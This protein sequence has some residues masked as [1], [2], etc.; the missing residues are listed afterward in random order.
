MLRLGDGLAVERLLDGDVGHGSRVRRAVRVRGVGRAP[1]DGAGANLH[2]LLANGLGPAGARGDDQGLAK[3]VGVPGGSGARLKGDA[4]DADARGFGR[5]AQGFDGDLAGEPFGRALLRGP[6]SGAFQ[7]HYGFSSHG[8]ASATHIG[9]AGG[10]LTFMGSDVRFRYFAIRR[11]P[12][13]G[14]LT[15]SRGCEGVS[16]SFWRSARMATRRY[17]VWPTCAGPQAVRSSASWVRTRPGCFASS[18]S[19]VHSLGFRWTSSP[20]RR[21]LR[22]RRSIVIGPTSTIWRSASDASRCRSDARTR[23]SSSSVSNG[24]VT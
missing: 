6:R 17:S 5:V 1:G 15:I 18:D 24:L 16:S 20:P 12:T 14:S 10:R 19:K 2:P 4:G 13:P 7:F 22:S 9:G 21:T 23:A 8:Y 11:Y 3:R